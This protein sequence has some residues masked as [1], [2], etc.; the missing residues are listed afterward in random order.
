M[1]LITVIPCCKE[2]AARAETLLDLIYQVDGRIKKGYCLLVFAPEVHKEMRD[3]LQIA[4]SLAFETVNIHNVQK[5]VVIGPTKHA[6]IWAMFRE[7]AQHM[8][9]GYR[10]PWLWC[11][12]DCIPLKANWR[13]TL[14]NAYDQQ[15]RRYLSRWLKS[16]DVTF[17]HHVGVYPV[18]ILN[19]IEMAITSQIPFEASIIGQSTK[20]DLIQHLPI[21]AE[22][23]AS[24]VRSDAVLL[25]GDKE[26]LLADIVRVV[27]D[28]LTTEASLNGHTPIPKRKPGRPRKIKPELAL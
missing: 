8:A 5:L 21:R 6:G 7:V 19:D 13:E 23:D 16:G 9:S 1:K 26:G 18:N 22:T 25:H 14:A 10:W 20:T 2:D 15:P 28:S 24:K 27:K 11:E 12:P 3:K 4:A 17:I